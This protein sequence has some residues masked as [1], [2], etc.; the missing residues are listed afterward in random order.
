MS[1]GETPPGA[2]GSRLVGIAF[3]GGV[4]TAGV[5]ALAFFVFLVVQMR[6]AER[7]YRALPERRSNGGGAG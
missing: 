4:F 7:I 5:I 1:A 2:G 6:L 3:V